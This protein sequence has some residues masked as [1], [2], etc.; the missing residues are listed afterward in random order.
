MKLKLNIFLI[1]FVLISN[2]VLAQSADFS[3]TLAKVRTEYQAK[4]KTSQKPFSTGVIHKGDAPVKVVYNVEGMDILTLK[5]NATKDGNSNDHAAFANAKLIDA[6]GAATWASSLEWT[7][8]RS[9]WSKAMR[10]LNLSKKPISIGGKKYDKGITVHANGLVVIKL[11]KKYKT[12]EA[13]CA[14]EDGGTKRSSIIFQL[15][16]LNAEPFLGK[17]SQDHSSFFNILKSNYCCDMQDLI[18]GDDVK[19]AA[20]VAESML[21]NLGDKSFYTA[22]LNQF[23]N[24]GAKSSAYFVVID[25]LNS[26]INLQAKLKLVN[27]ESIKLAIDDMSDME[28][29]N[30]KLAREKFAS[31]K[32][33]LPSLKTDLYKGKTDVLDKVEKA[34]K[35]KREILVNKT[36]LNFDELL[37]VNQKLRNARSGMAPELGVERANWKSLLSSSRRGFDAEIQVLSDI[38]GD[39]QS[40][41]IYAGKDK[42]SVSGIAL[43]WDAGRFMFSSVDEKDRWQ[44][45]EM[46]MNGYNVKQV[47]NV[48]EKDLEFF[49]PAYLPSGKI[50]AVSNI[51]FNGVPCVN[52]SDVVGNLC[53]YNPEDGELRRLNFGQDNDWDPVVM[54]NGR[55]QYLR[56]EYTDNT[57][58]F[59]RV[60]M[61]MNPDGTGK[62]ELYGSGSYWPNSMFD[63]TPLPGNGN[64]SYVAIVT[65]HHGIARS[66]RM[67]IFDPKK[68]RHEDKGVVQEIPYRNQKVEPTVKDRLVDG[69]WPQFITPV[70]LNE[71][72]YL[73]SAKMTPSSLWG[74]YLVDVFDNMTLLMETEGEG[75]IQPIPVVKKPTPPIIPEKV[76][77]KDSLSTVYIQDIY[78][79]R[80]TVGVPRGAIKELRVFAYEYA[81]VSSP[82][83]HMAQG[84]E[85]GWDIKR[86]L[87]TVPVNKDGSVI[88]KVPANL[89]FSMQPI[90]KDGAAIQWMRSWT[91]AMPGEV[92]SCVGCHE[93]QNTVA[94]PKFTMAS[95]QT[96]KILTPPTMGVRSFTFAGEIQPVLNRRCISCHN[97]QSKIPNFADTSM[98]K[99]VNMAKSY[100]ALHPFVRRQGP[101][102]DILT[103]QPYEYHV[104]TSKLIKKLRE[105]HH[106]VE[107]DDEEWGT[108]YNWID[109]NAP[110]HGSFSAN[111]HNQ[112]CDQKN[113]R[114]ELSEKYNSIKVD[115]EKELTD[116]MA[117]LEAKGEI[118]TIIPER[119]KKAEVINLTDWAMSS[120]DA[121]ALQ[122]KAGSITKTIKINDDVSIN[123][124]KIPAGKFAMNN[125]TPNAKMVKVDK[126]FWMAECEIT[127]E[128]YGSLFPEH[129]SRF[130]NQF[131]KDHVNQGYPAN[132]PNQPVI[133]V[134]YQEAVQFCEKLSEIT[135]KKVS[136]PS[137]AQWEWAARSGAASDFFFGDKKS[138]FASLANLADVSLR[139]M[140]VTG[141]DPKPMSETHSL[142]PYYDFVPRS[143]TV[144]DGNMIVGFVKQYKPNAFG[145]YDMVG[146][147]AEWTCSDFVYAG[148]A[149]Y[150]TDD[151]L[152]VAKGFSW[153]DRIEEAKTSDREGYLP[154][155]K[156]YNVGFRIII[157]E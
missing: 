105:G 10:N 35:L 119:S 140:A 2:F 85:S 40:K 124:V 22:K 57:H 125:N 67:V 153:R 152:K 12:F 148:N 26:I 143:Q 42:A 77:L 141:V 80:G 104:S 147:V 144:N 63:A 109:F 136:L 120:T 74:I 100:L 41:T 1:S 102:A 68:A 5:V 86:E 146:N 157:E 60:L 52:G 155:Q 65:G 106:N 78:E 53:L 16:D 61:H 11:D 138:D 44:V 89:P 96:P 72:Y 128:Q 17:L 33:V 56:W 20:S 81:Y 91:T 101:E 142:R 88:F 150:K 132:K 79:G 111:D 28:G 69:V 27:L 114:Q 118:E 154:W 156:V 107:L 98:D 129:D 64:T 123:M 126:A 122:Q 37:V 127:N 8:T 75:Y 103:M 66:G 48:D 76:N 50:V 45:Y 13:L 51:G 95:R 94:Q 113:R 70:P 108:L 23:K 149:P 110:Y 34:L 58:Y 73:V 54:N 116:Y 29:Y 32:S 49:D 135:G 133:R 46:D 87:G 55:L 30:E 19:V 82:S 115:W 21:K 62:K 31:L 4:M 59:S 39:I 84:I 71:K 90:D 24:E 97:G 99:G 6:S 25:E 83:N 14:V 9:G 36:V 93:D 112:Y 47:T 117:K 137:E 92:V 130:I 121:K 43:H 131:W 15:E 18:V 3:N 134:S 145:L 151:A 38:T 7:V 139:D